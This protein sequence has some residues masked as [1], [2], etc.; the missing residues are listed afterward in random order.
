EQLGEVAR[1]VDDC[2]HEGEFPATGGIFR[3][4]KYKVD[5]LFEE[6]SG[7]AMA[8]ALQAL[9]K[10]PI[11]LSDEVVNR[12]KLDIAQYQLQQ[13]WSGQVV[14]FFNDNLKGKYPFAPSNNL[15][16]PPDVA[17]FFGPQG[18][19]AEFANSAEN[20]AASIGQGTRK[21]LRT[22]A[23]LRKDLNMTDDAFRFQF[24]LRA[25]EVRSLDTPEGNANR[26]RIDKV[27]L[28][29]NGDVLEDRLTF[30]KRDFSW[31]SEDEHSECSLVLRCSEQRVDV[32]DIRFTGDWSLCRL[33]DA[34]EIFGS[35]EGGYLVTWRFPEEGVEVEF[36]MTT[37]GQDEPFFV[38]K[39]A[40]RT[41]TLPSGVH[42]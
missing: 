40:F 39:S 34:A 36:D 8:S 15:V 3:D 11:D 14:G 13:Q 6:Y 28:T 23:D 18:A 32:A 42:Q 12:S 29:I 31:S 33:F 21:A 16:D 19:M 37:P 26:S 5:E 17:A 4:A 38:P 9:M 35:S 22:A 24:T 20:S 2:A 30:T 1:L 25:Q 7:N 41:F 10:S 27:I